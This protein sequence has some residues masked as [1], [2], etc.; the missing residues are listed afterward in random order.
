MFIIYVGGG[1][2]RKKFHPLSGGG[3]G[4]ESFEG[5][6]RGGGGHKSSTL[7]ADRIF[8]HRKF[9]HEMFHSSEMSTYVI[10]KSQYGK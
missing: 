4:H 8:F 7:Q 9:P 6:Q 5:G 1:G 2:G 10:C 3:G